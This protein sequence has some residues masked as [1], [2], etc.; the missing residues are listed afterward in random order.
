MPADANGCP[1]GEV[2]DRRPSMR[3]PSAAEVVEAETAAVEAEAH[4]H[5][6]GAY[7]TGLRLNADVAH[8]RSVDPAGNGKF[9][10]TRR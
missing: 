7:A 10:V 5:G 4:A 1:P 2:A 3:R 9:T 6:A 8:E